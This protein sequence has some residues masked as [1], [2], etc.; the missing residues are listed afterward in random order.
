M[1][2]GEQGMFTRDQR[3]ECNHQFNC[4][5]CGQ[6]ITQQYYPNDCICCD[7]VDKG[8]DHTFIA[9]EPIVIASKE[10]QLKY[11]EYGNDRALMAEYGQV[12]FEGTDDRRPVYAIKEE[13]RMFG[14]SVT[15]KHAGAVYDNAMFGSSPTLDAVIAARD[16]EVAYYVQLGCTIVHSE[17]VEICGV[18]KGERRIL[19]NHKA[20]KHTWAKPEKCKK[21]CKACNGEG[22]LRVITA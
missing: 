4:M 17:I 13:K 9:G 5:V 18:C 1:N 16:K 6:P 20:H 3:Y 11:D 2:K 14:F 8:F 7:C 15:Y 10:V 21:V 19:C 12:D 22:R